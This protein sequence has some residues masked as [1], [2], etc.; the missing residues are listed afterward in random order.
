[1]F[2]DVIIPVSEIIAREIPFGPDRIRI[3]EA[4]IP[5]F[6]ETEEALPFEIA[7]N[8]NERG[9]NKILICAN[10]FRLTSFQNKELYGFDQCIEVARMAKMKGINILI[11]FVIANRNSKNILCR[12][13][14]SKI[15]IEKLE[16]YIYII[17]QSISFV[18]L[19]KKCQIV[20]RPTLSDGDAL[21]V[22]EALYFNKKV[23]ASDIVN[24]PQGTILYKS[25]DSLDLF[26]KIIATIRQENVEL[27]IISSQCKKDDYV[28]YYSDLYVS[29]YNSH[30][31]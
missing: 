21:T 29:C 20:L 28:K 30:K 5:P 6:T 2:A 24:R 18:E 14:L 17:F 9:E 19:I 3:K 15:E 22:R 27:G 26:D 31:N 1:L 8:I 11:I 12:S 13:L 23:I 25:G 16:N 10:A 4:F 7:K